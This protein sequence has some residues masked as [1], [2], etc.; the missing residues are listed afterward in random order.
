MSNVIT[1]CMSKDGSARILIINSKDIVNDAI[2]IHSLTPTAAAALGRTLTASALIGVMLKNKTDSVTVSFKGNGACG[3]ILA[4]SD[5]YGN[6]RGYIERPNV[7]LPSKAKGKLDV[8][9]AVG[10]GTLYIIR[11]TG[12]KEPYVGISPIVSG[13]IAE[14]IT[15]YF[16]SSEQIPTVCGLGV[17]IDTDHTC[18]AAGGFMIQLLPG[19]DDDFVTA[20]EQR[21]AA[22]KSVS[23]YFDS[24]KDN[25]EILSEIMGEIEFDVFDQTEVDYICSCSRERVSAMLASLSNDELDEMINEN[26][27]FDIGCQF[28]DNIY[29]FTSEEIKNIR[30]NK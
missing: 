30:D 13:E 2:R 21:V 1:R 8:A 27:S 6:V 17:L 18:K 12:E 10:K 11:D 24:G 22:L 23:S 16:A 19:A 26:K 15:N 5:Y 29:T 25:V 20:V 9:S 3:K 28:C 14:D 4:V 7:D